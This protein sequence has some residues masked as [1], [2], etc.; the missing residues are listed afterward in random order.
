MGVLGL[1]L[2]AVWGS[3]GALWTCLLTLPAENVSLAE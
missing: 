3:W 2:Y 1:T